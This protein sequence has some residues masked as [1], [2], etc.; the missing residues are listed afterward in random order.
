[1]FD[2]TAYGVVT[3][4]VGLICLGVA[5]AFWTVGGRFCVPV[6]LGLVITGTAGLL[7]TPVGDWVRTSLLWI[8]N[9]VGEWIGKYTV[10]GIIGLAG[11]FVALILVLHILGHFNRV[12]WIN[13]GGIQ[14]KTMGVG[15]LFA[16]LAGAIPGGVGVVFS[17]VL[18]AIALAFSYP[19]AAAFG[20]A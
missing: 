19:I 2:W 12:S 15:A 7:T 1:M 6:I 18:G 11:F 13:N 16:V 9:I 10:I 5:L 14:G 20:L 4:T 3:A 8:N 17:W